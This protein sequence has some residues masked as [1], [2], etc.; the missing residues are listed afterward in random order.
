MTREQAV[1]RLRMI[2]STSWRDLQAAEVGVEMLEVAPLVVAELDAQAAIIRAQREALD[3]AHEVIS[4][5]LCPGV[6]S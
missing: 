5:S 3:A 4:S 1:G 6:R 2:A